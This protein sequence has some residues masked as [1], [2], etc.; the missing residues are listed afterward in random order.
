LSSERWWAGAG[1]RVLGSSEEVAAS[2]FEA[3]VDSVV[4]QRR[5]AHALLIE[6][7]RRDWRWMC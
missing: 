5:D 1:S 2:E 4:R 3:G 6:R 7:P